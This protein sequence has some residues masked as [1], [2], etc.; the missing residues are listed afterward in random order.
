MKRI[1]VLAVMAALILTA[2]CGPSGSVEGYVFAPNGT[3]PV[4]GARVTVEGTR[5]TG[6]SDE[7]G[8]Y[9]IQGVPL[10]ER[11]VVAVKGA[12]RTEVAVTV[13]ENTTAAAPNATLAA[14][15]KIGVVPGSYDEIGTILDQL[16]IAYVDLVGIHASDVFTT[17]SKLAEYAVIFFAC[18]GDSGLD[19][20]YDGAIITNMRNYIDDGGRIYASDWASNLV[21]TLFP[22]KVTMLGNFGDA[23]TVTGTI[24][25]DDLKTLL[26]KSLCTVEYDLSVWSVIDSVASD[27][28]VDIRGTF[29]YSD[30]DN[31]EPVSATKPLLIHFN[32]GDGGVVLTTF[33]NEANVTED[34]LTILEQLAFGF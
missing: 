32:Y 21:E 22:T 23:Q 29:T 27:V 19:V 28:E 17:P 3:D 26:G 12:F 2:G 31:P 11:T 25:N 20:D 10:G 5:A 14:L 9:I 16:G 15:G 8:H 24:L 4:F 34:S 30:Y 7:S 13:A 33:H 6:K 1:L 18:G